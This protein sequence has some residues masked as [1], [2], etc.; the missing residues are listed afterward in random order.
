M[1]AGI[2]SPQQGNQLTDREIQLHFMSIRQRWK[3]AEEKQRELSALEQSQQVKVNS[4]LR[5]QEQLHLNKKGYQSCFKSITRK[6][7]DHLLDGY[8]PHI[9]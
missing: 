8:N 3:E 7:R 6:K 1:S 9:M 4:N 5:Y 2:G